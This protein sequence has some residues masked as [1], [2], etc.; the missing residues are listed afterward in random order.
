M[1]KLYFYYV[2]INHMLLKIVVTGICLS[3]LGMKGCD[4][5]SSVIPFKENLHPCDLNEE[6]IKDAYG[7][8]S[9]ILY[10]STSRQYLTMVSIP[11]TYDAVDVGV[12]CNLPDELKTPGLKITFRGKYYKYTGKINYHFAGQTFYNLELSDYKISTSE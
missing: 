3:L 4:D 12:I 2:M 9:R 8:N 7:E 6:F 5:N 11:G 10:D 1:K